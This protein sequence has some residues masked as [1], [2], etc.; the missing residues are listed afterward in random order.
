[1]SPRPD[2]EAR[3]AALEA[4]V[5]TLERSRPGRKRKPILVTQEGVCGID[6]ERDSALCPDASLH[7]HRMGCRGEACQREATAYWAAY[8]GQRVARPKPKL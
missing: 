7:R 8:R 5:A 6:T 1:V 4:R 2:L 3:L